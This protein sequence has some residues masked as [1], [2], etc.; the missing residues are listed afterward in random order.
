MTYIW[1]GARGLFIFHLFVL[2]GDWRANQRIQNR[3]ERCENPQ[4]Q[5][6]L[7]DNTYINIY[8]QQTKQI[9]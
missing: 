4:A 2:F 1:L 7:H 9:K 5:G 8:N 6:I 3:R